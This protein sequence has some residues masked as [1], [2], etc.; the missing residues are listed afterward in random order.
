[1]TERD[2]SY[3]RLRIYFWCA[4]L[5]LGVADGWGSR[6]AMN[7]DGVCYLDMGNAFFHHDWRMVI[8]AYWSPLYPWIEGFFLWVLRPS[9]HWEFPLVHLVNLVLYVGAL[10]SFEFFLRAFIDFH[11]PSCPR[12]TPAKDENSGLP[13]SKLLPSP[14]LA[15]AEGGEG[16]RAGPQLSDQ[17]VEASGKGASLP[18]W[19]W[20]VIGYSLF[21][22]TSLIMIR[23]ASNVS[24]DLCVAALVYL[25]SGLLL[26][27][28]SRNATWR[29]FMAF[30][31]V[32]GFGYLAKAVMFPLA[33]VFLA[34]AVFSLSNL[35]K[36]FPRILLSAIVF[37][38]I[39]SPWLI[40]ISQAGGR[41]TF[42]D[43]GRV[44]YEYHIDGYALWFPRARA[45][46]HPVSELVESPPTYDFAKPGGGTY[47]LWYDTSYW[48][49]GLTP[50][51][52]GKAEL[53]AVAQS[54]GKY[55]HLV[56]SP[57]LQF[58]ML[59]GLVALFWLNHRRLDVKVIGSNWPVIVPA[60]VAV[61]G[62]ALVVTDL[63]YVAAYIAIAWMVLFS[64]VGFPVS[65]R[66]RRLATAAV[67][68]VG[69]LSFCRPLYAEAIVR[70][71]AYWRAAVALNEAGV[72]PGDKIA[73]IGPETFGI[74]VARLAKTQIIAEVREETS[75]FRNEQ[76]DVQA[77]V[78][79]ALR[80]TGARAILASA[81]AF[82]SNS[83]M[84]W[85]RLGNTPYAV[86]RLR[87]ANP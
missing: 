64:G 54:L 6:N 32:L 80:R 34:V 45:L 83:N 19:A 55:L 47:P 1:M 68:A 78:V 37:G 48:H 81:K 63:R 10:A 87:G 49:A 71:P 85:Q 30:G 24:P 17:S 58:Y 59:V 43:S 69:V 12:P 4:A 60:L 46:K 39:A 5:A 50:R 11:S 75:R 74:Y 40:L 62:Y 25:A 9:A 65:R 44:N 70:A 22:W 79:Q 57:R 51:F 76:P 38:A 8:N 35:R 28:R 33:F 18:K 52:D 84:H 56:L 7:P 66:S 61:G 77:R 2:A 16:A 13:A 73:V 41:L 15:R 23:A 31:A 14:L 27:M 82:D 26:R 20:Y 72:K 21:I 86:C 42:G 36:A 53:K 67:L 29:T 3:K